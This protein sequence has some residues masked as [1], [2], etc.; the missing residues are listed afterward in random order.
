[1]PN[2]KVHVNETFHVQTDD[3]LTEKELKH[4]EADDQAIQTIILGLPEDIYAAVDSCE[5]TQEI[6]LHVQQM[7]KGSDIGIQEKKDKLFNEWESNLKFL[8]N[9]QP[10]WS[11]HVTIVHQIKDLNTADYTQLYDF[12][13]YNQHEVD[14][15]KTERLAKTQDPLALMAT[16]NNPYSFLVLHQDQPSFNQNYMQ[17][18]M[19]NPKDITDPT[20]TMNMALALMA[21]AFKLNFLTPTNNNQRIS[22]NPRNRQI[23]QPGMNMGQDRQMQMVGD[24]DENQ[25]KQIQNVGNQNGLIV[26]PGNANQ[27]PNGNGNLVAARSEGN[28]T[29]HNGNQIR[30]YNC[31]GL[32]HFARNCTVRPK[33]RDAA[34][35]QTQLLIAQKEEAGIQLQAEEFDLMATVAD[36]DEIDEVTADYILMANM[37]QASTSGTQ[38]DKALVYDS[39][40]SAE[41]HNDEYCYDNEIFNM[42]TQEEQYTELLEPIS[43]PHQVP[44]NDN[45]VIYEVS[46]VE[47][48]GGTVEQHPTNIEE[49][50]VDNTK[51]RRP[52]SRSNTKNVRVPSVSKSSYSKN[53][54]ANVEEHHRKLLLS[55]NKKHMP[56]E[57]EAPEVI[58]TFLKRITILLQSYVI[59]IRTDND[60]EFKNQVLKE[61]FDSVGISHQ[62][63]SV[64]TPQQNRVA[65]R[66][67]Q[68][69]VEAA[70]TILIFSR[71][72]LFLWA[73]A[74]PTVCFTQNRSI[75]HCR[76]NKT[77]YELINGRKLDISF[78]HV[79]GALCY[80][81]NDH[82][83][84]GKLGT[85]GDIGFFIGYY[86]DSCAFRVYNRRKKKIIETM[87]VTFDELSI[88]D[89]EQR[90]SKSRLQSMTSGQIS[91]GLD[92]TYAL[93]TI[94]TQ[95]PTE[96][97]LDLLFEAMYDVDGLNSQQQ[98]AQ[99][100]GN[101]APIQPETVADNVLNAMF[102]A[103]TFV[104][105][106]ATPST[107][108]AES[109]SSQYF[110]RLDVWVLVPAP[111]NI[112]PLTLK[113]L[114]KNKHDEEKTVIRNKYCLV[115]RGYRQ[116][117]GIDFEESF[118]AVARMEAIRIFLAFAAHKS[119]TMFQMDVKTAFLHG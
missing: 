31:R 112:T 70:R 115:V 43:E 48:S 21:K 90:S 46:S 14:D 53:K 116:E 109:S 47:Q 65:K 1:D 22:S 29:E 13:K 49:R 2:R 9:L 37:Q 39:D 15:L 100:Q 16:S 44:Q 8:N 36:L 20:T 34:Y 56:S 33:T 93:S 25:F 78:L 92:L 86:V 118:A 5:T 4:I 119:F 51:I 103:N 50:R 82:E 97:E 87:N 17:Q 102:D 52:Q 81:K 80:L 59:I 68:T 45:N 42:F 108:A 63:S 77:P 69:L 6:W 105:P 95:Q 83:D 91:S 28:E 27:N 113:W 89:F 71:A 35:L 10:E 57:Y 32:G 7:M 61:Y 111:D 3:E 98:H 74:I 96:G 58:K 73:E 55:K 64:Q 19:P 30:C 88:M 18:P 104:N 107:S 54:E 62:V 40:R 99:Q 75:F 24:N 117:E 26:V 67:N 106:F 41:V 79:L 12:L 114:F 38:T 23:A 84:I 60:I 66:R 101:Q 11:R 85:K 76:F 72:P 110:K 94:T